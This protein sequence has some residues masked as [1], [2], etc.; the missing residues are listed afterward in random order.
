MMQPP[1]FDCQNYYNTPFFSFSSMNM[2]AR[3]VD[4]YDGDTITVVV[5]VFGD[6]YKLHVRLQG[7]DTAE[8][9][10]KD[11]IEKKCAL[12]AKKELLFFLTSKKNIESPRDL[13]NNETHL[14]YIKC[15][16]F[17]KYGRVLADV[18][19]N[20]NPFSISASEHLM[21]CGLANQY[22]GGKKSKSCI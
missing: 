11:A 5:H 16:G 17:D 13:L 1:T 21:T 19:P 10:S 6:F 22:T 7:I 15:S 14:C 3:V 12:D 9:H 20:D 8:M 2:F 4:V 18:Y